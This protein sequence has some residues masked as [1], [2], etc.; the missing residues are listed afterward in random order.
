VFTSRVAH[1]LTPSQF[2]SCM[3]QLASKQRVNDPPEVEAMGAASL[4]PL[5]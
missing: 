1:P 4:V 2:A 5:R 3:R